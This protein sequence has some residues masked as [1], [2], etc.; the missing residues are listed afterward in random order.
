MDSPFSLG[1]VIPC[2]KP[3]IPLLKE[4]LD[5]IEFQ[6]VKPTRVIV[7]CSGATS[8]DIPEDYSVYSYPL[9]II[10]RT[11]VRNQAENRNQGTACMDT[12]F[13]SYFDA[14]DVMHPQRIEMICK[15][16]RNTDILLHSFKVDDTVFKVIQNPKVYTNQLVRGP[17]GCVV[18][19]PDWTKPIHHAQVT[20]RKTL[21]DANI[22]QNHHMM[23][24]REDSLFCGDIINLPGAR[25][26]YIDETLSWYRLRG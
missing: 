15:Y 1:V 9:E 11:D 18:F 22:F 5:S 12:E 26:I 21:A 23:H 14:D 25:N 19:N 6:T 8:D 13:V 7:V 3:Y 4:C 24:C 2:H 16:I 17:T 10:T 20:V